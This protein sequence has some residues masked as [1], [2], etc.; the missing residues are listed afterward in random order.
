MIHVGIDLDGVCR[1]FAEHAI[2]CY[3]K[4]HPENAGAFYDTTRDWGFETAMKVD[5]PQILKHFRKYTFENKKTSLRIFRTAPPYRKQVKSWSRC[6]N[7]LK[8]IGAVVSVCTSQMSNQHAR[9]S[10][11]WVEKHGILCDSIIITKCSEK[12]IYNLDYHLD[13][14]PKN[15]FSVDGNGSTGVLMNREWNKAARPK[16]KTCVD[17]LLEYTKLIVKNETGYH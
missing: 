8:K 6:Y 2:A 17:S 9:V 14:K 16:V 15:V 3:K 12:G 10:V 7:M 13:D 5:N 11:D 1:R 4:D